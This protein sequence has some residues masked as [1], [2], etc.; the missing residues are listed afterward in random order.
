[1]TTM[2]ILS[3]G[4]DSTVALS[5]A[6][7]RHA[8]VRAITFD[9]G[10]RHRV[11]IDHARKIAALLGAEWSLV[12]L[13]GIAGHLTTSALTNRTVDVPRT[14]YDGPTMDK[15]VVPLR[16]ATMI[17]V[18]AGALASL[19]GGNL[20][21]GVH[22]ADHALY[23]DCRPAFVRAMQA[24]INTSLDGITIQLQTPFLAIDKADIVKVGADL[25]APME[26]TWSCY[27][28]GTVQCGTCGTCRE[29]RRA[30]ADA[31]ILDSTIYATE[32][33]YA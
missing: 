19:G 11:E 21:V 1:M 29:R 9:Y 14:H 15:T 10:Q 24:T 28:G 23:P 32:V 12:D 17:S 4:L 27:E 31:G 18:A 22:H 16:N 13:S 8:D 5:A 30:F 2:V 6:M 25:G 26:L 7:A 3:G 33:A 20:V